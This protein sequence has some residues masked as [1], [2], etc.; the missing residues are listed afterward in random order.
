MYTREADINDGFILG[1]DYHSIFHLEQLCSVLLTVEN[2]LINSNKKSMYYVGR[3]RDQHPVLIAILDELMGQRREV[4][5]S[6]CC[7]VRR[8]LVIFRSSSRQLQTYSKAADLDTTD[9]HERYWN[10]RQTRI[11][12]RWQRREA[13][14]LTYTRGA[15]EPFYLR[16]HLIPQ[17]MRPKLIAKAPRGIGIAGA[18]LLIQPPFLFQC[19]VHSFPNFV[20][21]LFEG[22]RISLIP[23]NFSHGLLKSEKTCNL[24]GSI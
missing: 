2:G 15:S 22:I 5:A 20:L 23:M 14:R 8:A 12:G 1:I 9:N 11:I 13:E 6:P 4:I 21:E 19:F 3:I 17:G 18:V 7:C 16:H 10:N 24:L